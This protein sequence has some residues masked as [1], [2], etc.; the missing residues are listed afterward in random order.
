MT[1]P[2]VCAV[3]IEAPEDRVE[4]LLKELE[5][6]D[7][8]EVVAGGLSKLASVPSGGGGGMV[9]AAPGG[10]GGMQLLQGNTKGTK[11]WNPRAWTVVHVCMSV[12][13]V[14]AT[15]ELQPHLLYQ[16]QPLAVG[17][18]TLLRR[19]RRRRRKKRRS[20]RTM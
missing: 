19:R 7:I 5:G 8:S 6:K 2:T 12:A 17:A 11:A 3:G 14:L 16:V 1:S 13:G 4:A 15:A 18:P 9:A 10:G 20:R